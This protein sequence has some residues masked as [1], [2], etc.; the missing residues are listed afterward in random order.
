MTVY[1]LSFL[2]ERIHERLSRIT[3]TVRYSSDNP[4]NIF[5]L[6]AIGLNRRVT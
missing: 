6:H 1:D 2:F 5:G 3:N 4:S